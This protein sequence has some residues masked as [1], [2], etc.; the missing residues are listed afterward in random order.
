MNEC[1][2]VGKWYA[3]L[4]IFL[5]LI[6]KDTQFS[7]KSC[8]PILLVILWCQIADIYS[9]CWSI[10]KFMWHVSLGVFMFQCKG[11]SIEYWSKLVGVVSGVI[12][13]VGIFSYGHNSFFFLQIFDNPAGEAAALGVGWS[14]ALPCIHSSLYKK[15]NYGK[16][17]FGVLLLMLLSFLLLRSRIGFA[18]VLLSTSTY[19]YLKEKDSLHF[20][21]YFIAIV[22]ICVPLFLVLYSFDTYSV[23][24]RMLTYLTMAQMCVRHPLMGYGSKVLEANY[25]CA[26]AQMLKVL[27]DNSIYSRVAGDVVR[28]FNEYLMF[29][30]QYGTIGFFFAVVCIINIW[31]RCYRDLRAWFLSLLIAW[32]VLGLASYPS[33]Y[34]YVSLL[35]SGSMGIIYH[36]KCCNS[37][38]KSENWGKAFYRVL[39]VVCFCLSLNIALKELQKD[40]WMLQDM[41]N[42]Q[43]EKV[44]KIPSVLEDDVDVVYSCAVIQN[45]RCHPDISA[46]LL[47]KLGGRL[48]N[49]DTELLSGDDALSL[50]KPQVAKAHFS[51]AHDMVPVRFMP[52]YGLMK[53]YIQMKDIANAVSIAEEIC[54]KRV[55]VPSEDVRFV[56]NEAKK[57]IEIY[58]K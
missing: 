11:V 49:Y 3:V 53:A 44:Y 32:G 7:L 6:I 40:S 57:I 26:Q 21:S 42:F 50:G 38:L 58:G 46:E 28:P 48:Q 1:C 9:K 31:R 39:G 37:Q 22:I 34:P 8:S 52:L 47:S 33:Y 5:G 14:C 45:L 23:K 4:A 18:A 10:D 15:N 24:G 51:L 2:Y 13:L 17:L 29:I 16:L 12:F 43:I 41:E 56:K 30:L 54:G 19:I 55:K 36:D 35:M 25:M 20:T 27:G